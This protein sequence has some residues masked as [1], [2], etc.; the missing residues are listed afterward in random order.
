MERTTACE[1]KLS[2][3]SGCFVQRISMK[4]ESLI[5]MGDDRVE[6]GD[7]W[8]AATSKR[9]EFCACYAI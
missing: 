1:N 9:Y 4:G 3:L 8:K 2:R 6:R 5:F 7:R